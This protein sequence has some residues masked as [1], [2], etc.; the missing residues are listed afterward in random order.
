MSSVS[1]PGGDGKLMQNNSV[2][3][4]VTVARKTGC[5]LTSVDEPET[6]LDRRQQG[7]AD[8]GGLRAAVEGGNH[9]LAPRGCC[10][11]KPCLHASRVPPLGAEVA[12]RV[13]DL[14]LGDPP[15]E[16][17]HWTAA[18]VA[19]TVGVSAISVQR[20]LRA[21]G[22]QTHRVHHFKLSNDPRFVEQVRDVVGLY[23]EP[24]A[25]PIVL[26]LDEKSQIQAL[27]RTQPGLPMKK[28]RA[29]TMTQDDK[30]HGTTTLFAAL[31]VLDGTVIDRN[32]QR[33]RHQEFIRFL[34]A[35]ERS[36][37]ASRQVHAILD[38]YAAHKHPKVREWL[39]RHPRWTFHFVPPRQMQ[40]RQAK[41]IDRRA[42]S[43]RS[44]P[45]EKPPITRAA[46]SLK[47][48]RLARVIMGSRDRTGTVMKIDRS[49]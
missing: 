41:A 19:T 18:M 43:S 6:P 28:G 39:G 15:A 4:G 12:E 44:L 21:H 42:V 11:T 48:I 46:S 8:V 10:A 20:I 24:P 1:V 49:P 25:H 22:L 29:G 5:R 16:T 30:R 27:D 35:I 34:G 26:S 9:G 32:M 36:V 23:L 14:T 40:L 47:S 31:N 7:H 38:N 3:L 17:T 45:S 33:H 13:V 37:P 2:T